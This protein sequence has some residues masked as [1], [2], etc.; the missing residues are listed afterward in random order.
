[1][2][3]ATVLK[4]VEICR[5]SSGS[6]MSPTAGEAESHRMGYPRERDLAGKSGRESLYGADNNNYTECDC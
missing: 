5:R 1:M 2:H 3:T 4:I 6:S